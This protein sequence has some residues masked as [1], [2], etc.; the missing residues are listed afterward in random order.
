MKPRQVFGEAKK[1]KSANKITSAVLLS[2]IV[3][4]ACGTVFAKEP[5]AKLEVAKKPAAKKASTRS[6]I[7]A[8]YEAELTEWLTEF[9]PD[10]VEK[11]NESKS[12]TKLHEKRFKLLRKKY[13]SIL[14]AYKKNPEFGKALMAVKELVAERIDIINMMKTAK[15]N[16]RYNFL[17]SKLAA[18]VSE[19]F[20]NNV[21]IKRFRYEE[22]RARIKRMEENLALREKEVE[23]LVEQKD[24]HIKSRI[25]DLIKGEE[26]IKWK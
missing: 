22:L 26:K 3:L 2:A 13:G 9:Y 11:L 16:K 20:D 5:T 24:D 21:T 17:R 10:E 14:D 1:M 23:K 7:K 19:E 8:A 15:S 12:N 25:D 18:I 6:S 4:L